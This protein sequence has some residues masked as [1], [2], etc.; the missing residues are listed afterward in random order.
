MRIMGMDEE[1]HGR[2]NEGL[3][4]IANPLTGEAPVAR[5]PATALTAAPPKQALPLT[6][7]LRGATWMLASALVFTVLMVLVRYLGTSF[8]A[9]VQTFYRQLASFLVLMPLILKRGSA[10]FT[11]SRPWV[12]CLLSGFGTAALGLSFYGFQKMSLAE[13]NA[14]SFTR[15]LWLVPLAAIVVRERVGVM[16]IVALF[17]GFGGVLMMIRPAEGLHFTIDAPTLAMLASAF[18]LA[19]TVVNLK[20]LTRDHSP[21]V[22]LVWGAALGVLFTLPPALLVWRWPHGVDLALLTLLGVLATVQQAF[23]VKGIQ[24]GDAAIMGSMDYSRLLFGA[25]AGYWL[26]HEVPGPWTLGGAV[27]I[28]ASTLFITLHE[29]RLALDGK[30]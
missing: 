24:L 28:V 14:L 10:A 3:E 13:A 9:P 11:A 27:I 16:R 22:I 25:V 21:T 6:S 2:L 1:Q 5:G 12:L 4:A 30:A 8:P 20:L 29:R 7:N 18:L 26:Y 19:M 17:A 23:F 15:A